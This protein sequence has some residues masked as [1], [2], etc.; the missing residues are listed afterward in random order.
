MII[1]LRSSVR[2]WLLDVNDEKETQVS[3][4]DDILCLT[5]TSDSRYLIT[6]SRDASLKM[7]ELEHRKLVQVQEG[8]GTCSLLQS[9]IKY[10]MGYGYI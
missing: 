4:S 3:H 10:S 5:V 1:V 8:I 2:L 6:G 9:P 7:W